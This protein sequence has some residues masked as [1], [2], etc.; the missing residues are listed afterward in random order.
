M[1][2]LAMSLSYSVAQWLE[3][4]TSILE[5]HEFDSCRGSQKIYFISNST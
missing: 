1:T 3:H 4:P 2:L 5:G